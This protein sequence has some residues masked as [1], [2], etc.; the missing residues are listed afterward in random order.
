LEIGCSIL[1]AFP[2]A[3]TRPSGN[4]GSPDP[5]K[6][7]FSAREAQRLMIAHQRRWC[8]GRVPI[9]DALPLLLPVL[10]L[11]FAYAEA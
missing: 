3:N 11:R 10:R 7:V 9:I 2:N 4:L 5:W 8:N 6:R 1:D